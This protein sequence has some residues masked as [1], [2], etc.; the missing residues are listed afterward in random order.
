MFL[1][2]CYTT[3][4]NEYGIKVSTIEHLMAAFYMAGIDNAS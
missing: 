2:L 3:I 4:K 1:L